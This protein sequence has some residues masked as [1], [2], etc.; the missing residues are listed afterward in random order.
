[1]KRFL[2]I[3]GL[4]ICISV[5]HD[6]NANPVI[7]LPPQ[8]FISELVFNPSHNWS[9]E[10]EMFIDQ[11]SQVVGVIDSIVLQCGSSRARLVSFPAEHYSLFTITSANLN[12]P[13][14]LNYL[15]DTLRVISYAD[16]AHYFDGPAVN[17]HMLVYGY[18]TCEIPILLVGQSI[19]AREKEHGNPQYFYLD[20]SPTPGAENDTIGATIHL[21]G[22]FYDARGHLISY[23]LN[24]HNFALP[25]NVD[26]NMWGFQ[27]FY[28]PMDVFTF[29][30]E[31]NFTTT[32][33]SRNSS[34][35]KISYLYGTH[36]SYGYSINQLL[37][38]AGFSFFTGP[39][40]TM[41][42]DIQLSDS[43]FLVG[44]KN[45]Q[46]TARQDISVICAPNPVSQSGAF[47]ITADKP[48][49]NGAII[50]HSASGSIM[51]KLPVPHLSNSMISFTREQLGAPGLC[52]F[53][54][55][56]NGKPIKSGDIICQ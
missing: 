10:M 24:Q 15:Q 12:A 20:N 35:N 5:L 1:M 39:G 16:S 56:Q 30:S 28:S 49:E 7:I 43:S 52:F 42:H 21:T 4:V 47:L 9:L 14:T 27:L 17:T 54:L 32:L 6:L 33:L 36:T 41:L 3:V 37:P 48:V 38:C 51:L 13:F 29:D 34:F 25:I 50:I 19:C 31:G 55:L 46:E 2:L 44:I 22:K 8:A 26:P 11:N 53:T 45:P 40:E 23:T 18:P